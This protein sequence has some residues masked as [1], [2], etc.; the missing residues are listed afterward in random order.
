MINKKK[1]IDFS[2]VTIVNKLEVF[3]DF[4]KSVEKQQDVSFELIPIYNLKNEYKSARSAFNS[5]LNKCNGTYVIFT[6]PDIRF[7][8]I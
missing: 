5:V 7:E 1:D 2:I 8:N 3:D 6:H 4:C